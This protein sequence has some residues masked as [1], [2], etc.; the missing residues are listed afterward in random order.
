M[1]NHFLYTT[2]IH[3]LYYLFRDISFL[4]DVPTPPKKPERPDRID[5]SVIRKE[6][7]EP[8]KQVGHDFHL[9]VKYLTH[10]AKIVIITSVIWDL[11]CPLFCRLGSQWHIS[12]HC[13]SQ[14]RL[15]WCG[16]W[17]WSILSSYVQRPF[18]CDASETYAVCHKIEWGAGGRAVKVLDF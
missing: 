16:G 2:F 12:S 17:C 8:Q 15:C 10:H 18:I 3:Y 4:Y 1:N 9:H 14:V 6:G 13:R 5:K 7:F 11:H